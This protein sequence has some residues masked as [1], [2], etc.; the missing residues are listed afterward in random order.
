MSKVVCFKGMSK[1]YVRGSPRG[2]VQG[3]MSKGVC[4]RV[5]QGVCSRGYVETSM[6][7]VVKMAMLSSKPMG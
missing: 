4:S 6:F 3:G 5:V 7:D 1:K 2:Y